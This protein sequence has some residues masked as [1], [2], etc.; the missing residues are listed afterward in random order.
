MISHL[1]V[2]AELEPVLLTIEGHL[3]ARIESLADT[4]DPT[5]VIRS[6]YDLLPETQRETVEIHRERLVSLLPAYRVAFT[7]ADSAELA[8]VVSDTNTQWAAIVGIHAQ[9]FTREVQ[10]I[11][12]AAYRDAYSFIFHD[13]GA[14]DDGGLLAKPR[15]APQ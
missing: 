7:A 15:L 14:E 6:Y 1:S 2:A 10:Q 8:Q 3:I 9:Q 11:L 5:L 4:A 12:I 13:Q